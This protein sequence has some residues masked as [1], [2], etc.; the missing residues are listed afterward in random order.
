MAGF[1]GVDSLKFKRKPVG[2]AKVQN[3]CAAIAVLT[4]KAEKAK[5]A[6]QLLWKSNKKIKKAKNALSTLG[7]IIKESGDNTVDKA[8]SQTIFV[9]S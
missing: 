5:I 3:D 2:I 1:G 4:A 8:S 7:K 9:Q 6:T